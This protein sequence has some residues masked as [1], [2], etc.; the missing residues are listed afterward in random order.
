MGE[1]YIRRLPFKEEHTLVL[2][3]QNLVTCLFI[4]LLL[5]FP[6]TVHFFL[7]QISHSR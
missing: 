7:P 4:L 3:S 5:G 6:D 2:F 1:N